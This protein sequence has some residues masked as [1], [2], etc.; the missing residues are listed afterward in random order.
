[1]KKVA[2]SKNRLPWGGLPSTGYIATKI[3]PSLVSSRR[4]RSSWLDCGMHTGASRVK[5][6]KQARRMQGGRGRAREESGVCML[7]FT[8]GPLPEKSPHPRSGLAQVSGTWGQ[9]SQGQLS[10]EHRAGPGTTSVTYSFQDHSGERKDLL[11]GWFVYGTGYSKT[12]RPH[13]WGCC[14][15]LWQAG[16]R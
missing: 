6:T 11:G 1:M 10:L 13:Q 14:A 2:L 12:Q 4:E 7:T 3:V 15:A 9:T 16:R 5:G 8:S